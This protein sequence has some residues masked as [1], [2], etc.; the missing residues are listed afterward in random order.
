[1]PQA[2][3]SGSSPGPNSGLLLDQAMAAKLGLGTWCYTPND[4]RLT[5]N[6]CLAVHLSTVDRLE[7]PLEDLLERLPEKT[8]ATVESALQ[9]DLGV[10]DIIC[11][12]R[13]YHGEDGWFRLLGLSQQ[14]NV[15]SHRVRS[16][17]PRSTRG[18]R[19]GVIER[20]PAS[21]NRL[22]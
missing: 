15:A 14:R 1:L 9:H 19:K 20:N 21:K 4:G 16:A 8:A 22:C 7:L 12:F 17:A 6:G 13:G 18:C 10:G 2:L 5:I 11:R 3:R